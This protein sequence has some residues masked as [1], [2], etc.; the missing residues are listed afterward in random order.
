[1]G[2]PFGSQFWESNF[3]IHFGKGIVE[4]EEIFDVLRKHGN[5][6]VGDCQV[7]VSG[8]GQWKN[9]SV[10]KIATGEEII[11]K[12][13][14]KKDFCDIINDKEYSTY[15]DGLLEKAMI[16]QLGDPSLADI[17]TESYEDIRSLALEL[18]SME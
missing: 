1:M 9:L 13:F 6:I 18:D 3:Q 8:T 7:E 10:A 14:R 12:K 17:D 5:D 2:I 11:S 15:I 16:K 4:H